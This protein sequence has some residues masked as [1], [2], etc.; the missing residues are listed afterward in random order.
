MAKVRVISELVESTQPET[1]EFET[2]TATL[3]LAVTAMLDNESK[4]AHEDWMSWVAYN[5]GFHYDP[6]GFMFTIY[7][8]GSGVNYRY[9]FT[10]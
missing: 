5:S 9:E 7:D 2:E 6:E 10:A 4:V 8:D 1:V 3:D